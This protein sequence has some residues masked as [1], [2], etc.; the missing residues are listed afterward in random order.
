MNN[1]LLWADISQLPD[2]MQNPEATANI[3]PEQINR[4]LKYQLPM[5]RKQCLCARLMEKFIAD[6]YGFSLAEITMGP[7]GKPYAAYINY[8]ISHSGNIVICAVSDDSVGCDVELVRNVKRDVADKYFTEN[9]KKLDF[10][11]VWTAKESYLKM[12][13]EGI[14]PDLKNIEVVFEENKS[15]IKR[16][17]IIEDCFL[18]EYNIPGYSEYIISVCSKSETFNLQEFSY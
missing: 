18:S 7:N 8:N 10:F 1:I 3:P 4:I 9:E 17:G 6:T 2:I 11:K 15:F 5:N 12:T 16:N 14:C 13:G